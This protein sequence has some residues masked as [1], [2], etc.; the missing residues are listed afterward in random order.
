[1]RAGTWPAFIESFNGK[2]RQKCLKQHWF[3]SLEDAE[4]VI[5]VWRE[6][7]NEH[8]PHSLL[9]GPLGHR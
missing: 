4:E 6:D 1:M 9:W 8:R 5:E 3:L 2:F 7:Y